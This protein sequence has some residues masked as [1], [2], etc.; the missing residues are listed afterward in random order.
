[1][2]KCFQ[3]GTRAG[4]AFLGSAAA[5]AFCSVLPADAATY[6]CP[7]GQMY[8][9]SKKTCAPV[10]QNLQFLGRARNRTNSA[11]ARATS[12]VDRPSSRIATIS[13]ANAPLPAPRPLAL[14]PYGALD[15]PSLKCADVSPRKCTPAKLFNLE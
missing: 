14:S 7:S 10:S 15:L 1:M 2:A 13:D 11:T 6:R 9:V 8:R 5:L 12:P 3:P 4:L